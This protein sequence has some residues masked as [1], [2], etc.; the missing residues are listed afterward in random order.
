MVKERIQK[1]EE[2]YKN[3]DIEPEDR[4]E[5]LFFVEMLQHER[6]VHLIITIATAA[7]F[8]ISA[9]TMIVFRTIVT[10]LLFIVLTIVTFCYV[11]YYCYLENKTQYFEEKL[12][13]CKEESDEV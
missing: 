7:V 2:K 1:Y 10:D 9:W 4:E 12:L 11:H 13:Q 6:L 3:T 5:M 8:F